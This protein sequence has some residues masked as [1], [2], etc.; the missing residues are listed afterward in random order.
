MIL[1]TFTDDLVRET[2]VK[3]SLL[4]TIKGLYK[5]TY[6][7][8]TFSIELATP[9]QVTVITLTGLKLAM[10]TYIQPITNEA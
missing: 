8:F 1:K 4:T 2:A 7:Y 10:M 9:T 3:H 5:Y 6:L